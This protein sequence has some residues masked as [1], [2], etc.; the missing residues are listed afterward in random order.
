MAITKT[1]DATFTEDVLQH[2][3]PVLVDFWAPWCGPCKMIAPILEELSQEWG[4]KLKIV[5]LNTD[6]NP[7]ITRQYGITGIPTM[8]V[9]QGGEVVKT[10]V[11]ALPKKKLAQEMSAFTG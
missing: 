8:N 5:K 6:E 2:D 3:G 7:E 10:L 9:Y 4:D 1:S 11:G